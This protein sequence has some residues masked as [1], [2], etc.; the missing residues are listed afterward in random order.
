MADVAEITAEEIKGKK[1][2]NK[3]SKND[4]SVNDSEKTLEDTAAAEKL[5]ESHENGNEDE[6]GKASEKSNGNEMPELAEDQSTKSSWHH[7]CWMLMRLKWNKMYH[8]GVAIEEKN[9]SWWNKK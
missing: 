7:S 3:K 1:K 5:N 8:E 2:K 9:A 6:N 4:T